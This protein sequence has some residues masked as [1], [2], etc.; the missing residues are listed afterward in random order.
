MSKFGMYMIVILLVGHIQCIGKEKEYLITDIDKVIK[1]HVKVTRSI[2]S[3]YS[4]NEQTLMKKD[5]YKFPQIRNK[6]SEYVLK[7]KWHINPDIIRPYVRYHGSER[8]LNEY[9][10]LYLKL[11]SGRYFL[12]SPKECYLRIDEKGRITYYEARKYHDKNSKQ[13]FDRELLKRYY[14]SS[15]FLK[16]LNIKEIEKK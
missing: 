6:I 2:I 11:H 16:K 14:V 9:K 7:D 8:Y 12:S 3:E 1:I 13:I 4:I 5:F 10:G 15:H